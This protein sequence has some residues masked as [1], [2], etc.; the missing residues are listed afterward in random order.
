MHGNYLLA[1]A[2]LGKN[3]ETAK[4]AVRKIWLAKDY[5]LILQAE[6]AHFVISRSAE[7][8]I[9]TSADAS[10]EARKFVRVGAEGA[11]EKR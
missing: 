1:G 3:H 7:M 2:K 6:T 4:C 10:F 8:C 11:I 5:W 9:D